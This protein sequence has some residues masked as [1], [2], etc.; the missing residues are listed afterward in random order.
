MKINNPEAKEKLI[1]RLRRIEGQVRGVQTMVSEERDCQD[2]LQQL[3]AIRSA[4]QGASRVFLKEYATNCLLDME[5]NQGNGSVIDQHTRR[6]KMIQD[7]IELLD[8]AP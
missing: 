2:I 6:E 5:E 8:K 4:V 1:Q 7:M 3:S